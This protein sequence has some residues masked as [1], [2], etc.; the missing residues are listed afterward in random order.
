MA[1]N[2]TILSKFLAGGLSAEER[3]DLLDPAAGEAAELLVACAP[4]DYSASAIARAVEDTDT[5]LLRLAVTG[6]RDAADR[7]VIALRVNRS[8]A[9]GVARSL[10]RYG[11]DT[12]AS[13]EPG[14]VSRA[15]SAAS[16][17]SPESDRAACRAAELLRLLEV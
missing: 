10:A 11:Y 5:Q 12:I 15:C 2:D 17:P 1:K 4:S 3:I 14:D 7:P 13:R 16:A 8:H 9:D 6:L